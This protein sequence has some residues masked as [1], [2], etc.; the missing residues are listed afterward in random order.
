MGKAKKGDWVK[1]HTVILKPGQRA[2]KLPE[3]TLHVPLEMWVKGALVEE[4][5][6][7]GDD[8]TVRTITGRLVEGRLDDI[9]PAYRHSFGSFMPV[10]QDI[11]IELRAL[12]EKGERHDVEQK[13]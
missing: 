13:L 1:I 11:G 3:E 8:V 10:L 6:S 5:A 7:L 2:P 4:K 9:L 12:M